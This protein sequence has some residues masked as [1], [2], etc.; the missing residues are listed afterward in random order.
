MLATVLKVASVSRRTALRLPNTTST[1]SP[2]SEKKLSSTAGRCVRQGKSLVALVRSCKWPH[3]QA[4]SRQQSEVR[5]GEASLGRSRHLHDCA[6]ASLH[7][8]L[9]PKRAESLLP[10]A[11]PLPGTHLQVGHQCAEVQSPSVKSVGQLHQGRQQDL[12]VPL[13]TTPMGGQIWGAPQSV[14][15]VEGSAGRVRA[16][17]A[18]AAG[19]NTINKASKQ[20]SM[21]AW[22][23]APKPGSTTAGQPGK[24]GVPKVPYL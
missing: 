2:A 21:Q 3:R 4:G 8:L 6:K 13:Q 14:T 23:H 15:L 24:P 9:A 20:G 1:R 17:Q 12:D 16:R 18:H 5:R 7:R 19:R 22:E 11:L 10:A